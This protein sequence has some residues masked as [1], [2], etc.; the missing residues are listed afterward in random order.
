[1]QDM[2]IGNKTVALTQAERMDQTAS[3]SRRQFFGVAAA[4]MAVAWLPRWCIGQSAGPAYAQ[5]I[6]AGQ[7]AIAAALKANPQKCASI[8]VALRKGSEIVWQQ[9]FGKASMADDIQATTTTRYNIGS[10]SKLL[11]ALAA[12]IAQDR[13]LLDLDAPIVGYLPDFTMLSPEYAQITTRH[14]LSHSSGLPGTNGNKL[15]TFAPVPGYAQATMATL[16]NQHLKHRPGEMA[17]YCNDGFTMVELVIQAVSGQSFA[18]FVD[19]NILTPL[20]M[21][22]SSYL[23]HVPDAGEFAYPYQ[24]GVTYGIEYTNAYASGGLNTTPADM[25]NLAQMFINQGMFNGKRIVSAQGIAAMATDQ[26]TGLTLNPPPGWPWGLGWD[27]V[28]QM[29]LGAAGVSAWEKNGATTF[30]ESDFFVLPKAQMALL[31][32]GNFGYGSL[33]IAET[34]LMNALVEDGTIAAL[35]PLVNTAMPESA[36]PPDVTDLLGGYGNYQNPFRVLGNADGTLTLNKWDGSAWGPLQAETGATVFGYCS[37]GW[38]WSAKDAQ[39]SY[40]FE[41]ATGVD[42][43]GQVY[44]YRYLVQRNAR[45]GAGYAYFTMLLA[46]Q[47]PA[48]PPLN[49]VWRAHLATPLWSIRNLTSVDILQALNHG[50]PKFALTQIPELPGYILLGNQPLAPLADDRAGMVLKIPFNSSRD[51]FEIAYSTIDGAQTFTVGGFAFLPMI[52]IRPN[53]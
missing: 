50:P 43:Q 37:D 11:A 13:G 6:A 2:T 41:T 32:T 39:F 26:T 21:A 25:M 27:T 47:L 45:F 35:K 17:V 12:V 53:P 51:L 44:S 46:Q 4:G 30:F 36:P 24:A 18:A 14:L 20:D 5:T 48:L 38:W 34:I 52:S 31:I 29:A 10:I 16:A 15:F 19:E 8:S 23:T 42:A 7:A 3:S 28:A 33:K 49:A 22:R 40:R 1:M 9:A